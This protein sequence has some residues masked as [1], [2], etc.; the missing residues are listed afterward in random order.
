MTCEQQNQAESILPLPKSILPLAQLTQMIR[1]KHLLINEKYYMWTVFD[2]WYE[3][4]EDMPEVPV[5]LLQTC[6]QP[7]LDSNLH[8][9][10]TVHLSYGNGKPLSQKEIKNT[11]IPLTQVKEMLGGDFDPPWLTV[12]LGRR[13]LEVATTGDLE[14]DWELSLADT[15]DCVLDNFQHSVEELSQAM[16]SASNS[17]VELIGISQSKDFWVRQH[18]L[19]QGIPE[20]KADVLVKANRNSPASHMAYGRSLFSIS[21][22][23][24]DTFTN[25]LDTDRQSVCTS[26]A[27][28]GCSLGDVG[29]CRTTT[30]NLIHETVEDIL[31]QARV[32][33]IADPDSARSIT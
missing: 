7:E 5:I 4:I 3:D 10:V 22:P 31:E 30:S 19:D 6:D 32:A 28:E 16:W 23:L 29:Y 27:C 18:F 12:E 26:K 20:D 2:D 8:A 9:W 13:N 21:G 11:C 14:E 25:S 33:T 17:V 24:Q 15:A 1:A